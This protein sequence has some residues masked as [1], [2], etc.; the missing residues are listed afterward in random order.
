MP[1]QRGCDNEWTLDVRRDRPARPAC[2]VGLGARPP[3]RGQLP[4]Q[5][6]VRLPGAG[7]VVLRADHQHQTGVHA[8]VARELC[9]RE[10]GRLVLGEQMLHRREILHPALGLVAD[11]EHPGPRVVAREVR[12]VEE[13]GLEL[14]HRVA[15]LQAAGEALAV[16]AVD[17]PGEIVVLPERHP[18]PGLLRVEGAVGARRQPGDAEGGRLVGVLVEPLQVVGDLLRQVAAVRV[19]VGQVGRGVGEVAQR[20]GEAAHLVRRQQPL[21]AAAGVVVRVLEGAQ[22]PEVRPERHLVG[23]VA[24][25]GE[26][27]RQVRQRRDVGVV[28]PQRPA[29]AQVALEPP[30]RLRPRVQPETRTVVDGEQ[31]LLLGADVDRPGAGQVAVRQ[32]VLPL[33]RNFVDEVARRPVGVRGQLRAAAVRRHVLFEVSGLQDLERRP[34]SAAQILAHHR[35]VA[36]QRPGAVERLEVRRHLRGRQ[37][38]VEDFA[39]AGQVRVRHPGLLEPRLAR[40]RDFRVVGDR[41]RPLDVER[42]LDRHVHARLAVLVRA[43]VE[44]H[45]EERVR[46]A[47]GA[48]GRDDRS[49]LTHQRTGQPEVARRGARQLGLVGGRAQD[50]R[51]DSLRHSGRE[52]FPRRAAGQ[53]GVRPGPFRPHRHDGEAHRA[54]RPPR[55][56]VALRRLAVDLHSFLRGPRGQGDPERGPATR[57]PDLRHRGG[58]VGRGRGA[59]GRGEQERHRRGRAGSVTENE[60]RLAHRLFLDASVTRARSGRGVRSPRGWRCGC[61]RPVMHVS[62]PTTSRRRNGR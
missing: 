13:A 5:R 42:V 9:R 25:A 60:H 21:A 50:Q 35:Q 12:V 32:D 51:D 27:V 62:R 52:P 59:A 16:G 7:P 1:T 40:G 48:D 6:R 11:G 56:H 10:S 15:V 4:R 54:V 23:V 22:Q 31:A 55:F 8:V 58:R 20:P 28:R 49:P 45:A 19:V 57:Q 47:V 46:L 17:G 24:V 61:P 33:R 30:A 43:D 44:K 38:H 34:G 2:Q 36:R 29:A 18:R 3:R 14:R 26:Q 53:D 41:R 37:P 39:P